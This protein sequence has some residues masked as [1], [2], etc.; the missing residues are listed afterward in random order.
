MKLFFLR[1]KIHSRNSVIFLNNSVDAAKPHAMANVVSFVRMETSM[2]IGN[3]CNITGVDDRNYDY[4]LQDI[5]SY[6]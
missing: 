3:R 5:S 1:G 4:R 2:T 6:R